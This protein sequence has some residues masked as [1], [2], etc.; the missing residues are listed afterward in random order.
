[1]EGDSSAPAAASAG[2]S[3]C[4]S[5]PLRRCRS[6]TPCLAAVSRKASR[7][8]SWLWGWQG[9]PVQGQSNRRVLRTIYR[10]G[11]RAGSRTV[12]ECRRGGA[13]GAQGVLIGIAFSTAQQA[14]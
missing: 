14:S 10:N 1:M 12:T 2:S 8:G 6:G 9:S 11:G 13:A 3:C 4:A 7:S 5:G